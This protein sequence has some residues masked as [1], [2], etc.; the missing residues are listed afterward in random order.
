MSWSDADKTPVLGRMFSDHLDRTPGR[1]SR[2]PKNRS[3][4]STSQ[5]RRHNAGSP[6]RSFLDLLAQ[7][8]RA[9]EQKAVCLAGGVAFNCVANGKIFERHAI[10]TNLRATCRGRRGTRSWRR[11]FCQHQILGR[12]RKFVMEHAY[13]GPGYSD[14]TDATALPRSGLSSTRI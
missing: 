2:R 13:W 7:L 10:R 5:R 6:G 12:P 1:H 11:L 3:S 14:P 4:R 9:D 8:A